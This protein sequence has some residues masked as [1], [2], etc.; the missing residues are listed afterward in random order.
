MS[1]PG[2]AQT[3]V[4]LFHTY[5]VQLFLQTV[6]QASKQLNE[7]LEQIKAGGY[8]IPAVP[9][10]G[11][12]PWDSQ[13]A[14]QRTPPPSLPSSQAPLKAATLDKSKITESSSEAPTAMDALGQL[15]ALLAPAAAAAAASSAASSV[16][17]QSASP[18]FDPSAFGNALAALSAMMSPASTPMSSQL[19]FTPFGLIS[20]AMSAASTPP[21][22]SVL[23]PTPGKSP[24]GRP[25]A[26]G[27]SSVAGPETPVNGSPGPL[28]LFNTPTS[29]RK[30]AAEAA[31]A[32]AEG[33]K[34]GSPLKNTSEGKR[35]VR[36]MP[37][38]EWPKPAEAAKREKTAGGTSRV[39]ALA[40]AVAAAAAAEGP[41][42]E[43]STSTE[44]DSD[45]EGGGARETTSNAKTPGTHLGTWTE[46]EKRDLIRV[47]RQIN[48][49]GAGDWETVAEKLG[50]GSRGGAS[51]ERMYRTLT[52]PA[53]HKSSNPH[54]RRLNPRKGSTP[55]HVMAT[56]AL[57]K[58]PNN[59]GNLSQIG[60]LI[61]NNDFFAKELD[62]S[63]RPGTK[64]YPRWKD[65]LVGC[66]KPGRYPHLFKTDRKTDGLTVYK[67]DRAKLRNPYDSN[68]TA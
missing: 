10:V 20:K 3:T 4:E 52:D 25:Q 12:V 26:K 5:H 30:R 64:T 39:A 46:N 19:P 14:A 8:D 31:S 40:A 55:M 24:S 58:L 1:A 34:R 21:P 11:F 57:Q 65:A 44:D 42:D 15:Q 63:P 49:C 38:V 17:P 22:V 7:A 60:E 56:Y 68:A 36:V 48:P 23:K 53:Y 45:N 47:V 6:G 2:D 18:A 33:A 66:F 9:A 54:G 43:D 13:A 35:R 50:R 29:R 61:T 28:D 62:W 51:A 67:L 32:D 41:D 16:Q 27:G 37:T 59:E